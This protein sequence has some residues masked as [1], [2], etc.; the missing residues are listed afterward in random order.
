MS[1][2]FC[3]MGR[4]AIGPPSPSMVT[5]VPGTIAAFGDD[6]RIFAARRRA[7]T[8]A[9]P[10]QKD[11]RG[12]LCGIDI[13]PAALV[14]EQR[15]QIVDSVGVVGVFV[16]DQ[17]AVEP[18]HVGVEQLLAKV[19]R[20]VDQNPGDAVRTVPFDQQRGAPPPVFR[21][22]RVAGAPAERRPR[23]AHRRPAAQNREFHRHANFA[24]ADCVNLSA[25]TAGPGE[26]LGTLLNSRKKF[27]VVWRAISASL[28]PRTSA[29]TLAVSV[30]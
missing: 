26:G 8:I 1:P 22:V 10:V 21:I 30:T 2:C 17:H 9:E 11:F 28:T 12:R 18:W 15:P 7:E 14:H 13:E 6:R 29:S 19:G 27:S 23:H 3:R 24:D 16:G 25:A 5:A 20:G 4:A